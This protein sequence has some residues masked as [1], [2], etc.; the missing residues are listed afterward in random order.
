MKRFLLTLCICATQWAVAQQDPLSLP[1]I[2]PP[3]PEAAA[4]GKYSDIPVNLFNGA[5]MYNLPLFQVKE[6]DLGLNLSLNYSSSG[7][8]PME[9]AGFTGL[10]W[11]L[12][13][14]GVI[15]RTVKGIPDEREVGQTGFMNCQGDIKKYYQYLRTPGNQAPGP[16]R[17]FIQEMQDRL[18]ANLYD[19]AP[20]EYSMQA[21]GQSLK[22]IWGKGNQ[23]QILDG[24]AAKIEFTL[25]NSGDLLTENGPAL[26]QEDRFIQEFRI[27]TE[28]GFQYI[29]AA[30][31]PAKSNN[32]PIVPVSSTAYH[33]SAW[34]LSRIVSP[35]GSAINYEYTL[36][37]Q[38]SGMRELQQ[39]RATIVKFN[40]FPAGGNNGSLY[41]V[42]RP[43]QD[44]FEYFKLYL[45]KIHGEGFS[46]D[47]FRSPKKDLPYSV[48]SWLYNQANGFR[49]Y[50][51]DSI[52]LYQGNRLSRR[53]GLRY[54]QD[55]GL[56][57]MLTA[58]VDHDLHQADSLVTR[59]EYSTL[60]AE[61][62]TSKAIDFWG[63][64][65]GMQNNQLIPV[66][67]NPMLGRYFGEANRQ[68]DYTVAKNN[69]LE[70][71]VYPTGG[72]TQITYE[73]NDYFSVATSGNNGPVYYLGDSILG[74]VL[75]EVAG[76]G[77]VTLAQNDTFTLDHPTLVFA[78][79]RC[80]ND[81]SQQWCNNWD[82]RRDSMMVAPGTYTSAQMAALFGFGPLNPSEMAY[83]TEMAAW[84]FIPKL[85]SYLPFNPQVKEAGGIRVKA[86]THY[87]P[88][89]G[90]SITKSYVYRDP[91]NPNR[92][93]GVLYSL[94]EF[95]FELNNA[96]LDFHG[97][98]YIYVYD[99]HPLNTVINANATPVG[100]TYVKEILSNGGATE[101]RYLNF[102]ELN[103]DEGYRI[104][105]GHN[106]G[107][108]EYCREELGYSIQ[109]RALDSSGT[110]LTRSWVYHEVKDTD[111]LTVALQV[112]PL[113]R[114]RWASASIANPAQYDV[115]FNC[116]N[117]YFPR[118][119]ILRPVEQH[120]VQRF[121]GSADIHSFSKTQYH[122]QLPYQPA[123]QVSA[124]TAGDS[125]VNTFLYAID[126]NNIPGLN[127]QEAQALDLL[128][129]K[130]QA[131]ALVQKQA[132]RNTL[133]TEA[134]INSYGIFNGLP[135]LAA[136]KSRTGSGPFINRIKYSAY[137]NRGN[138]QEAARENDMVMSYIWGYGSSL[139]IAEVENA[140]NRHIAYTSF[141]TA[142]PGGWTY[143]GTPLTDTSAPTGEMVYSLTGS[144]VSIAN[145][146]GA[147]SYKISYW[148]PSPEPAIIAG[149]QARLLLSAN[150]WHCF[151]HRVP[152]GT[153]ALSISGAIR[154]DELRLHPA[155]AAMR[156]Y[157]YN[158][159]GALTHT[160]SAANE[161][162]RYEYDGQGRLK[163]VR[164]RKGNILKAIDYQ[165]QTGPN[166]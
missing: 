51:L 46:V 151:E 29:F 154:I 12:T 121:S 89:T 163:Q 156:T 100:Y 22:F 120:Q 124:G 130:N 152:A 161:I 147:I 126:K 98:D 61:P 125:L 87:D 63:Y 115:S 143:N 37:Y 78:R 21:V 32:S 15:T 66:S 134:L 149:T 132:Y 23:F 74:N 160:C 18:D 84:F 162:N 91:A 50:K 43:R 103:M 148:T 59:F 30:K 92:S 9:E 2:T 13:G 64:A 14:G 38:N 102:L 60:T 3:S 69:M 159:V 79:F 101:T 140:P 145:L 17:D 65:N 113:I 153:T 68:P 127:A 104:P 53:I 24:K 133:P 47:F 1:R 96:G 77:A 75:W 62:Y 28:D 67:Y 49:G 155:D 114:H 34:Y 57:L 80:L 36:P 52:R 31:E 88:V 72:H 105:V 42:S 8:M 93:S 116:L 82:G 97:I 25:Q 48:N 137:D 6:R 20:D 158:P 55:S 35:N 58:V 76:N 86:T 94:P 83:L 19:P 16:V 45:K 56:R 150:G 157:A 4:L 106:K 141:E 164:D 54:L 70:K 109:N 117:F 110:E 111:T 131:G 122:A 26:L 136:V 135:Q 119:Y 71:I 39:D 5:V 33:I 118:R 81:G 11:T 95:S 139:P 85:Y 99:S 144:P 112:W 123:R 107:V 40:Q 27:T 142:E 138:L 41:E 10:G 73:G 108:Q 44:N 90:Q 166:Q 7:F 128:V 165:Y 146:D 129:A